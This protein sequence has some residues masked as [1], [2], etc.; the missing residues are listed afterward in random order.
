[1]RISD[2]SSDVCSSDLAGE[3]LGLAGTLGSGRSELLHAIFGADPAATGTVLLDGTPVGR[4]PDEAVAAGIALVPEDRASQ[5]YVPLLTLA[6]NIALPRA[7]GLLLDAEAD[8]VA[9][10]AAIARLAIKAP[11]AAALPGELSGGNA[12]KGVI[13]KWVA[14]TT[15]GLLLDEPTAGIDI[16]ARTDILRL[17]RSLADDG[18]P[19]IL[20][21]SRS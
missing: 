18:L 15:R 10:D 4:W 8:R 7:T 9:A 20:V 16:G 21:S 12:Q 1:M 14:A 5:G 3:V 2:W 6:E 11:G 13:T 17:V 19:V